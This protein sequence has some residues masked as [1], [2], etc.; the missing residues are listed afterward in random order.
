MIFL[1][2]SFHL[3]PMPRKKTQL[4]GADLPLDN[5]A[6]SG[7]LVDV[8]GYGIPMRTNRICYLKD[9]QTVRVLAEQIYYL[10]FIVVLCGVHVPTS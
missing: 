2:S 4:G 9:S 7:Q 6:G 10:I 5:H 8:L 1:Y 3:L